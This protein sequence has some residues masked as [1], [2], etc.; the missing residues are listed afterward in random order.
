M[1]TENTPIKT[2]LVISLCAG[3][4]AFTIWLTTIHNNVNE[5]H[6]QLIELHKQNQELGKQMSELLG[7]MKAQSITNTN[8]SR[9]FTE[10]TS[11]IMDIEKILMDKETRLRLLEGKK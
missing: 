6:I 1:I 11:H 4:I 7:F 10:I 5:Q 2:G 3:I 9:E 8:Q